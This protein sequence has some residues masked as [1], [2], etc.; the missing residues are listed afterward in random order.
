LKEKIWKRHGDV[1]YERTYYKNKKT[2]EYKYLSDDF[3]GIEVHERMDMMLQSQLVENADVSYSKSGK[4]T[5]PNQEFSDLMNTIR[6]LDEIENSIV[7]KTA[8]K[9]KA[10][11]KSEVKIL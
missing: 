9:K 4:N 5:V 6:K 2:G 1:R 3:L 8:P 7:E 10:K 11:N